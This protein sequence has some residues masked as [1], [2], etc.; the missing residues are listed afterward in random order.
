MKLNE[1]TEKSKYLKAACDTKSIDAKTKSAVL[2]TSDDDPTDYILQTTLYDFGQ[3]TWGY[4]RA[5]II[6]PNGDTVEFYRNYPS[7][8]YIYLKQNNME[9][10]ISSEDY[11]GFTVI[12]LTKG[13]VRTIL[14]PGADKGWGWCPVTFDNYDND[15]DILTVEGCYWGAPFE[16]RYYHLPNLETDLFDKFEAEEIEYPDDDDEDEEDI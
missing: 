11:Q 6:Y 4:L 15:T 9:Y 5:E 2:L 3:G 1:L 16:Y 14:N 7:M 13:T 8:P 10:I 12:N